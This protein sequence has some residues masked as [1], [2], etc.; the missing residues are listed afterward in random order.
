MHMNNQ[1]VV[2]H[3]TSA[4]GNATVV[5]SIQILNINILFSF[6]KARPWEPKKSPESVL[7]LDSQ[8]LS[9]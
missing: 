4:T 2:V 3:G 9:A 1:A 5:G 7:T 6:G 8:V